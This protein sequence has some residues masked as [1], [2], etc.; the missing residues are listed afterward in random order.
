M[1]IQFPRD[2]PA[3]LPLVELSSPTLPHALLRNKE[4]ECLEKAKALLGKPQAEAIYEHIATFIHTNLFIP[5]WKEMKQVAALCTE[6][7]GRFGCDEKLGVLNI[8][9]PCGKYRQ[10]IVVT[11][12]E[13]YPEKAIAVEIK[14]SNFPQDIQFM[15]KSQADELLRRCEAGYSP[16]AALLSGPVDLEAATVRKP[17][18][19]KVVLTSG[20]LQGLKRDVKVL[21]EIS[22]LR[23][24]TAVTTKGYQ[25][26]VVAE[27]REARKD[28]RRLAKQEIALSEAE[29][30]ELRELEQMEM[31]ALMSS[32]I[33]STAPPSLF[34][35]VNFLVEDFTLK[36]PQEKCQA[37]SKNIFA[38]EP[39]APA[40][41]EKAHNLRPMR[42][43]C[44]HWFH[45]ECLNQWLTTPPF[46]RNCALCSR[47]IWHPDWYDQI[48]RIYKSMVM[49]F[50]FLNSGQK[51]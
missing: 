25:A 14:S 9:I 29:E 39:D 8:S 48:I 17:G 22:E 28:L 21:K 2:Y 50:I 12:P 24:A 27:R 31:K 23:D 51:M 34:A 3:V 7:G 44:G 19:S 43:F 13:M 37:C 47:R 45:Y 32:K 40:M 26:T 11:V 35:V 41:T 5:C 42:T 6:K 33:S 15:F 4:K 36:L 30:K 10:T 46:V 16:E 38:D 20:A 18:E 49:I 1:R